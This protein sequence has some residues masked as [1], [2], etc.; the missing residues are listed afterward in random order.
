MATSHFDYPFIDGHLD[1]LH[2]LAIVNN[3]GMLFVYRFCMD[4]CFS[5]C[6]VYIPSS[7]IVG[8]N[9]NSEDIPACFPK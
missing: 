4:I 1:C 9:V 8:P 5:F 6:L 3:G 7:G 2:Y